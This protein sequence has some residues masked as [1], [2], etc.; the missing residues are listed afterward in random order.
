MIKGNVKFWA[1]TE[2]SISSFDEYI[3]TISK[4]KNHFTDDLILFRGQ[5]CNKPL[6][7][8]LGRKE[9][10]ETGENIKDF[11]KEIFD[12]F[13][14]R[15]IAYSKVKCDNNWDLLALAQH[16]GL[17]T[18]LM[19]WTESALVALWF[20]T[21]RED[22]EVGVVFILIPEKTDILDVTQKE[23]GDVFSRK[24]TKFFCPN[25]I[26]ERITA[27][28]GW[29]SCHVIN[30]NNAFFKLESMSKYKNKLKKITIK[31]NIFPE[32]R[33]KL[34]LMGINGSTVYPDLVGLSKYLKWK[35]LKIDDNKLFR[36]DPE[37][38]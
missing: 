8:S 17:P 23:T 20:A 19:D 16:H 33:S 13:K 11:E 21:E 22:E 4:L 28:S 15:Y 29:F 9:I 24:A 27:Q 36:E 12:D 34:N 5:T 14:K 10:L 6:R 3:Q 37:D 2:F 7:P 25:H 38:H 30:S 26:S 31:K 32:I 1:K 18:R 35:H